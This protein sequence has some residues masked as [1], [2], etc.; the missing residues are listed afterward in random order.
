MSAEKIRKGMYDSGSEN[1]GE[2]SSGDSTSSASKGSMRDYR[3]D[4]TKENDH[5]NKMASKQKGESLL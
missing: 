5:Y 4:S 3:H 2:P 1:K